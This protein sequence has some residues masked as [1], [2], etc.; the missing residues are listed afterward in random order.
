VPA[1]RALL[2]CVPSIG[3]L[4]GALPRRRRVRSLPPTALC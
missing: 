1:L 3:P 4:R 2:P